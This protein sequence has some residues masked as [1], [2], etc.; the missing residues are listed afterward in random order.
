MSTVIYTAIFGDYDSLKQPVEQDIPC[1]FICFTDCLAAGIDGA[2][3]IIHIPAKADAHPRMRAKFFKLMS[4]KIFPGGHLAFRYNG[5]RRIFKPKK[6]SASIWI[7]GRFQVTSSSFARD[8]VSIVDSSGWAMFRHSVRDCIYDEAAESRLM[9]KYRNVPL[10]AQVA[11]YRNA[12]FPEK[13]GLYEC[14]IIARREPLS[15]PLK[16]IN[17]QWWDDN[18]RWTYQD[19]VSL[20][21]VLQDYPASRPAIIPGQLFSNHWTAWP[22][23]PHNSED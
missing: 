2:W 6:Y 23:P 17:A 22:E 9:R 18:L 15:F 16:A 1:D 10:D 4:H 7:D 20:P 3:R 8:L 13:S 12:G 21:F 11:A 19:Q 14:G 5:W